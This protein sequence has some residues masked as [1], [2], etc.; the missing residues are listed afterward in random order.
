MSIQPSARLSRRRASSPATLAK[1]SARSTAWL[2]HAAGSSTRSVNRV[3]V[4]I[5]GLCRRRF[6]KWNRRFAFSGGGFASA[7]L[8]LE[9]ESHAFEDPAVLMGGFDAFDP[10][11]L[12]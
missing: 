8:R 3:S 10:S 1:S 9:R 6:Q 4:F 5:G 2:A 7:V 12:V 11:Q